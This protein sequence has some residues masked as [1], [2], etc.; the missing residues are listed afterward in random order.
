MCY[1]TI[2]QFYHQRTYLWRQIKKDN[3]NKY[4]NRREINE[5]KGMI[6]YDKQD[7]KMLLRLLYNQDVFI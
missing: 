2:G 4:S 5:N 7:I 3:Y 6:E 1:F